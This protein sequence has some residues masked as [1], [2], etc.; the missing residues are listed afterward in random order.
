MLFYKLSL[1]L[2]FPFPDNRKRKTIG[3]RYNKVF[4]WHALALPL[5]LG[6]ALPPP[7]LV[8]KRNI[9][10]RARNGTFLRPLV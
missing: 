5:F 6:A 7:P 8:V 3:D 9:F 10:S 2:L 1:P 4:P